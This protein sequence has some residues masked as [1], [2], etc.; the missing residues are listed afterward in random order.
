MLLMVPVQ[1]F[2][3]VTPGNGRT[4]PD[5]ISG[6]TSVILRSLLTARLST[7]L[8]HAE[9]DS[10]PDCMACYSNGVDA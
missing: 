3:D 10:D 5:S 9:S 2:A 6:A 7:S 4:P 8:A 1:L